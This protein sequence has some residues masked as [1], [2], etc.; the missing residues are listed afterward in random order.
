[1]TSPPVAPP[2]TNICRGFRCYARID[3]RKF[4]CDSCWNR[5]PEALKTKLIGLVTRNCL[6]GSWRNPAPQEFV[7]ALAECR[8]ALRPAKD[9]AANA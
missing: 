3:A 7:D 6:D 1:M 4:F 5:L 2:N 8:N 9:G